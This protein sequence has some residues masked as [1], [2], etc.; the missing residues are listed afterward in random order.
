M[1]L[2]GLGLR[3]CVGH[4][5]AGHIRAGIHGHAMDFI[6]LKRCQQQLVRKGTKIPLFPGSS[7][8]CFS[9]I[10]IFTGVIYDTWHMGVS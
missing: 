5:E 3:G 1:P 6:R 9:L 4:G 10:S 7:A 2:Q 8:V